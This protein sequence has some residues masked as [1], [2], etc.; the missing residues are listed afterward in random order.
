[1]LHHCGISFHY[2][3]SP[4]QI[5]RK[6]YLIKTENSQIK[7]A[8]IFYISAQNIDYGYSFDEAIQ[9]STHNLCF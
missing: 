8:D 1:M 3:N 7:N 5:Y 9:T 6:F 4:M 2:E